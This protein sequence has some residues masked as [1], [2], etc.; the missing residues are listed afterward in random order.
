MFLH[1]CETLR[2][3]CESP[4]A[5]CRVQG[6]QSELQVTLVKL[7]QFRGVFSAYDLNDLLMALGLSV[8]LTRCETFLT[9]EVIDEVIINRLIKIL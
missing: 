4:A 8:S 2:F 9:L 7:L 5:L 1:T 6:V 3:Y